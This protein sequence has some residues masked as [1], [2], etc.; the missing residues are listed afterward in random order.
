MGRETSNASEQ[1][2]GPTGT[3]WIVQSVSDKPLNLD[4]R[5]TR[6][7]AERFPDNPPGSSIIVCKSIRRESIDF[8][9]GSVSA[10]NSHISYTGPDGTMCFGRI[11]SIFQEFLQSPP[12]EPDSAR[13]FLFVERYKPLRGDDAASDVY[14]NHPLVGHPGY[15]ILRSVYAE[16]CP[17]MDIISASEIIGHIGRYEGGTSG[18]GGAILVTIQLDRVRRTDH[19][20]CEDETTDRSRYNV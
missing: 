3:G 2:G 19:S 4:N 10:R 13:I 8:V 15:K 14:G 9:P 7:L 12:N 17:Q 16:F 20:G 11:H 5:N 18:T 1:I 6:V